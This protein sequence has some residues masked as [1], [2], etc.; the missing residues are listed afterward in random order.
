MCFKAVTCHWYTIS[1][2]GCRMCVSVW[3]WFFKYKMKVPP[4]GVKVSVASVFSEASIVIVVYVRS[5][6]LSPLPLQKE[7]CFFEKFVRN[8]FTVNEDCSYSFCYSTLVN[9]YSGTILLSLMVVQLF[10]VW[11]YAL[12][13]L[14][15]SIKICH[16]I[17][18][19][20]MH[21]R[22]KFLM[23]SPTKFFLFFFV[24]VKGWLCGVTSWK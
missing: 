15:I 1:W 13:N 11:Y 24:G 5:L 9:I 16:F 22:F 10:S 18:H 6:L 19:F 17:K 8:N 7:T 4:I 2:E 3:F 21:N 23:N 20:F 12:I 14:H